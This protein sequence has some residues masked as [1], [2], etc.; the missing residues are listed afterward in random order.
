MRSRDCCPVRTQAAASL[1][2]G[3]LIPLA[4]LKTDASE[5]RQQHDE[6]AVLPQRAIEVGAGASKMRLQRR[7]KRRCRVGLQAPWELRATCPTS[8][9]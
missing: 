1:N 5:F 3:S 8:T 6:L 4:S 9:L 7:I 2:V